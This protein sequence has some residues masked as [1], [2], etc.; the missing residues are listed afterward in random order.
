MNA[1]NEV[2][3]EEFLR[4][5][6]KFSVIAELVGKVMRRHRN[7]LSPGISDILDSDNW[8]RQEAR[9]LISRRLG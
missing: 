3:V 9:G 4:G 6:M 7:V 2:A 8:A 1:A 5:R